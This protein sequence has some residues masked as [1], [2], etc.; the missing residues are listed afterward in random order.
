MKITNRILPVLLLGLCFAG[1]DKQSTQPEQTEQQ[2][3]WF[4][5]NTFAFNRINQYYLWKS[6]IED[7]LNSWLTTE[8]PI[9]KV[10]SIRYKD[11]GWT[12]LTDDFASFYGNVSGHHKTYGFDYLLSRYGSDRVAILVACTY[13]DSPARKAGL[14][15][16]DVITLLDGNPIPFND[17][18]SVISQALRNSDRL[19]LGLQT[20][21]SIQLESKEMYENP[22]LLSKVFDCAGKKVGYLMYTNFTLDSY[23]DLIDAC[24]GFKKAG[25]RELIL[26][27]R[28]NNGGF[29]LAEQFFAS[30]LAPEA[31][32]QAGSVLST[33]IYNDELMQEYREAGID[34]NTYLETEY[35]FTT[36]DGKKYEFSTAGANVGVDKIYAIVSTGTASASEALLCELFPYLDITLVGAKTH[37]KYCS[38][39]IMQGPE[40]YKSAAKQLREKGI[41]PDEGQRY[42]DNWGI[43]VMC[44]RFA[45]KNG[46]TRCMPDGLTPDFAVADNPQDG[47][48]LGDPQETMLARALSLC[49]YMSASPR[50]LTTSAPKV[51]P[52]LLEDKRPGF[53]V[54]LQCP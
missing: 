36:T 47:F 42:T 27:L 13:A 3:T 38:G 12:M 33:E 40:F 5:A 4:Y 37:G 11:D 19:T 51:A 28:Y 16:G 18:S 14:K 23:K 54:Y 31:E 1:C 8:E 46:E 6:E 2:K 50:S 49:G 21:A 41:D 52:I 45:D 39:L 44:S 15:R 30:M 17:Y 22:V 26:D 7:D 48:A 24:L 43:Y 34:T 25:I 10:K 35:K 20:G 29:N 53:G 32:V 9:G